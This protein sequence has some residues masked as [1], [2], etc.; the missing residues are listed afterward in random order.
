[1]NNLPENTNNEV[2]LELSEQGYVTLPFN[3]EEFKEFVIGLL[4]KPQVIQGRIKQP[5]EI[6]KNSIRNIFELVNQRITQQNDGLLVQFNARI[7]FSD[8]TSVLLNSIDEL[9]TYNVIKPVITDAV[10]IIFQYLIKFQDKKVPEKQEINISFI[11]S[12]ERRIEKL[13]RSFDDFIFAR[14]IPSSLVGDLKA[15]FIEYNIKHTARTWGTDI[16]AILVN[17]F[18]SLLQI[19]TPFKKFLR[20]NNSTIVAFLFFIVVGLGIF[21]T[22]NIHHKVVFDRENEIETI[23]RNAPHSLNDISNQI[24]FLA[25]KYIVF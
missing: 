5:F 17:H 23:F 18:Q 19:E 2:K 3:K 8:N 21:L 14:G 25:S 7:V 16:E 9:I 15:G 22:K 4:G 10:H 6:D 1:M 13:H 20:K 11:S 12:N 24:K